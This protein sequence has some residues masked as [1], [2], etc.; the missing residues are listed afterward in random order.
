MYRRARRSGCSG[1]DI[2]LAGQLDPM[3]PK[4]LMDMTVGD[5]CGATRYRLIEPSQGHICALYKPA[6]SLSCTTIRRPGRAQ[7]PVLRNN[8]VKQPRA[9]TRGA[10]H[11]VLLCRAPIGNRSGHAETSVV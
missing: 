4:H 9:S 3:P 1:C 7:K 10:A 2:G 8:C 6:L 11:R 5:S